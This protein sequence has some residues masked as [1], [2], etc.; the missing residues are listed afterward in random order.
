MERQGAGAVGVAAKCSHVFA[1]P[2]HTLAPSVVRV[3]VAAHGE[4][5][6][7]RRLPTGA[8]ADAPPA[9]SAQTPQPTYAKRRDHTKHP[10]NGD[11]YAQSRR[12]APITHAAPTPDSQRDARRRQRPARRGRVARSTT[13]ASTPTH[14]TTRPRRASSCPNHPSRGPEEMNQGAHRPPRPSASLP[15]SASAV[16]RTRRAL[17]AL[18]G[19][20]A[21]RDGGADWSIRGPRGRQDKEHRSAED[22][23]I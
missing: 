19:A 14:S 1:A 13:T 3:G 20:V 10:P 9:R 7:T 23:V 18:G 16:P 8:V 17:P 12:A 11:R 15:A 6:P 22:A 2:T 21:V 5:Y 4:R